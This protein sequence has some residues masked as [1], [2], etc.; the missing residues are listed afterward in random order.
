MIHVSGGQH[1]PAIGW[2]R[3]PCTDVLASLANFLVDAYI[4]TIVLRQAQAP[5]SVCLRAEFD[6]LPYQGLHDWLHSFRS[7]ITPRCIFADA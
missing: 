3:E 2:R 4:A 6:A 7:L 1:D 5:K